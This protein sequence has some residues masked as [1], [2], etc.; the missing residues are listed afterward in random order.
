MRNLRQGHLTEHD[1]KK[2]SQFAEGQVN[3]NSFCTRDYGDTAVLRLRAN[4]PRQSQFRP[5]L[6][7]INR[8]CRNLWSAA[9]EFAGEGPLRL[10]EPLALKVRYSTR[11]EAF[12][13]DSTTQSK[14]TSNFFLAKRRLIWYKQQ[15]YGH[16]FYSLSRR[17]SYIMQAMELQCELCRSKSRYWH[18]N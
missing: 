14:L 7:L 6:L 17:M 18:L 13:H 2:Q 8:M 4:K 11:S 16:W 5:G 1:L 3:V 15:L 12:T 10:A 9:S